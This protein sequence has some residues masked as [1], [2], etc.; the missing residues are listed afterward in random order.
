MMLTSSWVV[1][2]PEMIK[3]PGPPK[4]MVIVGD[5]MV[6]VGDLMVIAW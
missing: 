5:L 6:I 2:K 1:Q 4:L 3:T